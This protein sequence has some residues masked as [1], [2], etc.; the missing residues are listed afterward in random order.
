MDIIVNNFSKPRVVLAALMYKA[1]GSNIGAELE[2]ATLLGI[3]L[4]SF[5]NL[6]ASFS[7]FQLRGFC[8]RLNLDMH[9]VL[10]LAG[11][12]AA[13]YRTP[14]KSTLQIETSGTEPAAAE[15]RNGS[16]TS[17]R[18]TSWG[19]RHIPGS[20]EAFKDRRVVGGMLVG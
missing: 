18:N 12:E 5:E 15:H 2:L 16:G 8:T 11:T 19:T 3:K 1:T 7:D 10:E 4:E 14:T 9:E 13:S 20:D 6:K 17:E